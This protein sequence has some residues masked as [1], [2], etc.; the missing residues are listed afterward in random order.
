MAKVAKKAKKKKI[1]RNVPTGRVY[2]QATFNNTIVSVTDQNGNVLGWASAG[3]V[4]FKGPKKATPYAA[5]QVVKKVTEAVKQCGL[6]EVSIFVKGIGGGRESAIRAF[7]SSGIQ[8]LAIKD[9]TPIPHN[10]C[11]PRKRRRV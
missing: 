9:V 5:S 2:I 8:V 11:R 6:K 1:V 3:M 7:N 4:G 10:G